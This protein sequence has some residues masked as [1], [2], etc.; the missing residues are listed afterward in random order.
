MLMTEVNP[1]HALVIRGILGAVAVLGYVVLG[2]ADVALTEG[3]VGT[4]LAVSLYVIAVR[5]SFVMRLGVI[6]SL[7]V[8]AD[9][10]FTNLTMTLRQAISKAYLRLELVTYEN[11]EALEKALTTKEVHG[12]CLPYTCSENIPC[13][14]QI[15]TRV[16][17]LLQLIQPEIAHDKYKINLIN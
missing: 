10:D 8:E 13:K 15:T 6:E 7:F 11:K 5:S 9:D 14:Y 2:A 3:L 17:R 4:M 12:I 1:Y 16:E